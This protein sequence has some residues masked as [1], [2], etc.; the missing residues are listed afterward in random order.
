MGMAVLN[1]IR[2]ATT[3]RSPIPGEGSTASADDSRLLRD[4]VRA[5]ARNSPG[6]Y[7]MLDESDEVIYV[8]KSIRLRSRLLSYFRAAADEKAGELIA[9]TRR[10]AW[11]EVPN[12]F[13]ALVHE[14]RLIQRLRPRFNVQHKRR[15]R[16]AFV[17]ITN[18][19]APRVLVTG[20]ATP[21]RA[22]YFGPFPDAPRLALAV[23]ELAHVIGLRNC[24]GSTPVYYA[25]QFELLDA[26]RSPLCWR[27]E[28]E[29]CLAP[30][31]ARCGSAD[32]RHRVELARAFLE[33]R[34]DEPVRAL[35]DRM[36][37][38][39]ERN[40]FEYAALLRDR[41]ERLRAFQE[42][43]LFQRSELDRLTFVYRIIGVDSE[44]TLYLIRRGRVRA[45]LR[46]PESE[47][48]ARV[49]GERIRAV[50]G[51]VDRGPAGLTP[52]QAAEVL[53]VAR[54]F[55]M[56]P[57]EMGHTVAPGAFLSGATGSVGGV[58]QVP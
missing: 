44:T 27:A 57:A 14:M 18:E 35:W 50:L 1:A 23:R 24:A 55:R 39:A 36:Q 8:G 5:H 16:Y 2:P 45:E 7:R 3:P 29:T 13:A 52:E 58:G 41:M 17:K 11:T 40:E 10:V 30:C 32:Y 37:G 19:S 43:M 47:H 12:E 34:T 4:H 51:E 15:R 53:L 20:R 46:E 28:I 54:W 33:G 9:S 42:E 6:V 48:E 56:H 22:R 31:A 21:D 49:A 38:A 26:T 25:D